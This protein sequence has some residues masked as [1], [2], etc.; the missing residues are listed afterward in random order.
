MPAADELPIVGVANPEG[1]RV[2]ALREIAGCEIVT[3]RLAANVV[4]L[5]EANVAAGA[6]DMRAFQDREIFDN[7][8][9]VTARSVRGT[10]EKGVVMLV[11]VGV[12]RDIWKRRIRLA[13]REKKVEAREASVSELIIAGENVCL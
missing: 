11:V 5:I 12:L 4:V 8:G 7:R 2:V 3:A 13:L 9:V 6:D 10:A 1:G